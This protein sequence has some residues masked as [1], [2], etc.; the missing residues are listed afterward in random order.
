MPIPAS[1]LN[2][3][4]T[5]GC[6]LLEI[7]GELYKW[8]VLACSYVEVDETPIRVLNKQKK[9]ATNRGYHRVYYSPD[10]KLVSFDYQ[11]RRGRAGPAKLLKDFQ[12][13]LQSD[14]YS[15]YEQFDSL[16]GITFMGCPTHARWKFEQVSA[17]D[18]PRAAKVLC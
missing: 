18:Q 10:Q 15:V 2:I 11:A 9:E 6:A 3:W 16:L 13:Y 7:I 17:N 8:Q 12:G 14:G 5:I 1:T 4:F